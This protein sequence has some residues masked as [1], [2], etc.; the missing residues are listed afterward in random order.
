M[1]PKVKKFIRSGLSKLTPKLNRVLFV[2]NF[3]GETNAIAMANYIA[4]HYSFSLYYAVK[5]ETKDDLTPLLHSKIRP[6]I[7][8]STRYLIVRLTSKYVFATHGYTKNSNRQV[9][10][11]LWHGVGHKKINKARG[12]GGHY[13]DYTVA[14]STFTRDMFAY[15]FDVPINSVLV[16]GYPRNDVL[17]QA[18]WNK[19]EVLKQIRPNL[20]SYNKIIF[21]MPTHRRADPGVAFSSRGKKIDNIFNVSNFDIVQF[22]QIL[23]EN[24]TLCIIKPH[25]FYQFDDSKADEMSNILLIDETWVWKQKLNLY[26]ILACADV[27]ITDFSSVM[28]DFSLLDL[29]IICF[30]SDLEE[31]YEKD[32][33]YFE[34]IEDYLPSKLFREQ[35]GFFDILRQ[36]IG[37]NRDVFKEK[38]QKMR[39]LYFTYQDRRSAERLANEVF[40]D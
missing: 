6:V 25:Y 32:E 27:L 31:V 7:V 33:L 19:G 24:N 36:T 10:I 30:C 11:N 9:T 17:I 14:T 15:F 1:I 4:E 12:M 8:G 38:R 18:R 28:T 5:K 35:G 23:R 3:K 22:N 2:D 16:S 20:E 39:D 37:G 29:P 40:R 34:N 13:A 26:Q 21:W